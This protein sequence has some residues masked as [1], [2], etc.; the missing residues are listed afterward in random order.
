MILYIHGFGSSAEGTK[1]KQFREYFK[2]IGESFIAPSLSHIP[3]LAIG[4]LEDII[5]NCDSDIKLMGSSLGG[6]YA[7][8]LSQKY[9]LKVVLINPAV[10]ADITLHRA[11]GHGI[12]YYDNSTY[13]WN[14]HHVESLKKYKA[15]KLNQKNIML[16]LQK[17][18]DVLD[19]KEALDLLPAASLDVEEGGSHNFDGIERYHEKIKKFLF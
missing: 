13:E 14:A 11:I 4:T 6:F 7:L 18:D 1:S 2:S 9:N 16:L 15:D 12:N 8:Y 5:E 17:G 3:A 10:N 19:Y